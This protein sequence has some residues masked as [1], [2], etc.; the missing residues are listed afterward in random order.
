MSKLSNKIRGSF[1]IAFLLQ[2]GVTDG[3]GSLCLWQVGLGVNM[4]KPYLVSCNNRLQ[5]SVI[6]KERL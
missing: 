4:T 3:E 6:P 5:I 1:Y 2:F